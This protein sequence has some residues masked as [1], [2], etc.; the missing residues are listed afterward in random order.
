MI[1]LLKCNRKLSCEVQKDCFIRNLYYIL[2][3]DLEIVACKNTAHRCLCKIFAWWNKEIYMCV[4]NEEGETRTVLRAITQRHL[5]TFIEEYLGATQVFNHS[6]PSSLV[7]YSQPI[8]SRL[9][10]WKDGKGHF[11]P[12]ALS[13]RLFPHIY[14]R[15]VD[16]W[17]TRF[18]RDSQSPPVL[19]GCT[20]SNQ[21]L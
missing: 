16:T 3:I 21:D 9:H 11:L 10:R 4:R 6:V 14:T 7:T 1:Y 8:F 20:P 12:F 13:R 19:G 15:N 2:R 5:K 18:V 17:I